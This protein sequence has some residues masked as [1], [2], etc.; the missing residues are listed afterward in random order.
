MLLRYNMYC[1]FKVIFSI[2]NCANKTTHVVQ[3]SESRA[4]ELCF[5]FSDENDPEKGDNI[6]FSLHPIPVST[7][8]T[9]F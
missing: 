6:V 3:I 9:L 2:L 8:T 4:V 7:I 1:C 5:H